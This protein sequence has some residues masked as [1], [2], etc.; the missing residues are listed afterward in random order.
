MA[1]H[2][3]IAVIKFVKT[4]IVDII[5]KKTRSVEIMATDD[6]VLL[7]TCAIK[8]IITYPMFIQLN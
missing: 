6:L 4:A 5:K 7:E 2:N 8:N 3:Y 1:N